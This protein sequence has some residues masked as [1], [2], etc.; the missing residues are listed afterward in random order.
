GG[1]G[2]EEKC[3]GLT[4]AGCLGSGKKEQI[5]P[6]RQ[7]PASATAKSCG[8]DKSSKRAGR[9]YRDMPRLRQFF[10]GASECGRPEMPYLRRGCSTQRII[11]Y[12]IR[13]HTHAPEPVV[14]G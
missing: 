6:G 10:P 11:T 9:I 2:G 1:G 4:G 12:G 8:G 3:V 14:E 5:C 13:H 7:S